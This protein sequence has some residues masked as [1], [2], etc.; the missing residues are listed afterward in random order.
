MTGTTDQTPTGNVYEKYETRNPIERYLVSGFFRAL[1]G[2]LDQMT[3]VRSVLDIG[4][5][6][7]Y[8]SMR[9]RE[10]LPEAD[11][12]A[13]DIDLELVVEATCDDAH[14]CG[15]VA[16]ASRLPFSEDQFDLVIALEVLEHLP[17]PRLALAEIR[18]VSR[19]YLI[20]SVPNEPLWRVLNMARGAYLS[21]FGNTPGHLQ[22]WGASSFRRLL[23]TEAEVMDMHRPLP[24]LMALC[25]MPATDMAATGSTS[26]K[27]E[28]RL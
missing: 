4:C 13:L 14:G 11:Y 7:G 5:G 19:T 10:A 22:H 26:A 27:G 20:A 12:F 8:A 16:D 3:D 2:L 17:E 15:V 1:S 28:T 9:I 23:E 21:D 18:R 24:W 25:H 6:E